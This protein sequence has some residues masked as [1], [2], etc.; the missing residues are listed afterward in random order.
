MIMNNVFLR[1][2][3]V[4]LTFTLLTL[5]GC[6]RANTSNRT[7][8]DLVT[9]SVDSLWEHTIDSSDFSDSSDPSGSFDLT[10][11]PESAVSS[12]PVPFSSSASG[13][14]S[15]NLLSS[16]PVS[17]QTANSSL[18]PTSSQK[19]SLPAKTFHLKGLWISC[20]EMPFSK[21]DTED[22]AK[23]KVEQMMKKVAD[24]G[25][26]A[27]FCHVRPFADAFYPSRYF[28][29]SKYVSGTEGLAAK[30]DAMA[31]MIEAAHRYKMQFHAWINPYR[32]SS[33]I[34]DPSKL[35]AQNIARTWATD[36]SGRA[37]VVGEGIYFNPA[38]HDVQKLVLNGIREIV[39]KYPV[40]GIH[41]DDYFYPTTATSFDKNSYAAYQQ[42][43]GTKALSLADWRRANV[44]A[45]VA[46]AH[47]ICRA[48]GVIFGISPAADIDKNFNNKYADVALWMAKA[49]YVDY[50]I[51]Q[52]YFG[53]THPVVRA[54]YDNLLAR[55]SALPRHSAL[56]FYIG[57]GAYRANEPTVEDYKE[58]SSDKQLLARQATD[59]KE[60]GANG[61]VVFSYEATTHNGAHLKAQ[62][63]NLFRAV[64]AF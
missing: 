50:I 39:D 15:S 13:N 29:P 6:G 18:P 61:F 42:S 45:L 53:Y 10:S 7:E 33:S 12:R 37:V 46:A 36:N 48:K 62:I 28:P 58:W 57:L 54:R 49:G 21:N 16:R 14:F 43:A 41:F 26:N 34:S 60:A 32:V 27:V 59:A 9:D 52:I 8:P 47:S 63:Q 1:F 2:L 40:D 25:Y 5:S 24:Q 20:F 22:S 38:E 64:E 35:S 56:S 17:S 44:N 55:W 51:P 30:F 19:P 4:F 11:V 23:K 3:A 31:L